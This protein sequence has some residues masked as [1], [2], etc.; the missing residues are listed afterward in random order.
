VDEALS[1]TVQ[2]MGKVKADEPGALQVF[3]RWI[4]IGESLK[5][6]ATGF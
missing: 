2:M 5:F 6:K 1:Q 4:K 3:A